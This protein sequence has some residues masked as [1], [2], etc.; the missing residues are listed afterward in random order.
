MHN[1]QGLFDLISKSKSQSVA[2]SQADELFTHG[3]RNNDFISVAGILR[4][5]GQ[6]EEQILRHLRLLNSSIPDPLDDNELVSVSKSVMR[7]SVT[8]EDFTHDT[9]AKL[10]LLKFNGDVIYVPAMGFY[11]FDSKV[12]VKDIEDLYVTHLCREMVHEIFQDIEALRDQLEYAD[13]KKLKSA[14][15]KLKSAG[16]IRNSIELVKADRSIIR[17]FKIFLERTDV[18]T[19]NNGTIELDTLTFR[20]FKREDYCLQSLDLDYDPAAECPMF[21][22]FINEALPAETAQF[23]L[24]VFGYALL[25]KPTE[26]KFFILQGNGQNGKSVLTDLMQNIFGPLSVTIQ[27]ESING[28]LDGQIRTDLASLLNKRLMVTSETKAGAVMDAPLMKQITGQD[29]LCCR[30]LYSAPIQFKPICVPIMQSNFLPVVDGGDDAMARRIV[31]VC[32]N[33]RVE[34]PD[35]SLPQKLMAERSGVFNLLLKSLADYRSTGLS[36]PSEVLV[37]TRDYIDRSNLMS[38]FFADR[39]EEAEG[40]ELAA[41]TLQIAY[42]SWCITNGYKPLSANIF[43][44]NFEKD[45]G[46]QQQRNDKGRYWPNLRLR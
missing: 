31:L 24:R 28:K 18:L 13:F 46:I 45:T 19:L 10:L 33:N 35:R 1:N 29:I 20:G 27:P 16:F 9:V 23:V 12:W 34:V 4:R 22:K 41:S 15:N 7:Y 40:F 30:E 17:D 26:Q 6:N 42:Q 37:K 3:R 2:K 36:I 39:I 43:K 21:S 11:Y 14:A 25:G 38:G 5:K 44:L 32:F 8:P